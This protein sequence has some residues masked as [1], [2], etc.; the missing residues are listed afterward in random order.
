MSYNFGEKSK[1]KLVTCHPVL[2]E[3][4]NEAIKIMDFVVLEGHRTEAQQR[5]YYA[6]GKSKLNGT[7][8]KSKHQ[9]TPSLAVD[10]APYPVDWKDSKR[11]YYLAGLMLGIAK[12]RGYELV[13]GGD[14]DS[15]SD[16]GDNKFNDLPH[17]ELKM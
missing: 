16:F 2:Q 5:A 11:F 14:W 1:S 4:C 15:D 13:W 9:A 3:I 8:K 17:F 6:E 7:T 10:I 12:E